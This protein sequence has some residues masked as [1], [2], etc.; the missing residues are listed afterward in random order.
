MHQFPLRNR[1]CRSLLGTASFAK[2][3]GTTFQVTWEIPSIGDRWISPMRTNR[4]API[5]S[6]RR[7]S[8]CRG[9]GNGEKWKIECRCRSIV[10]G[11]P[12]APRLGKGEA[13]GNVKQSKSCLKSMKWYVRNPTLAS[14][15]IEKVRESSIVSSLS[16]CNQYQH[17]FGTTDSH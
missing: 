8:E 4:L 1:N 16:K 17:I 14:P 5:S 2:L 9:G 10:G 6:M 15:H 13:N 7:F 12:Q 11:R 3:E